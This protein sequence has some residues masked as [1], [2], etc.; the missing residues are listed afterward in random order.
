MDLTTNKIVEIPNC[1]PIKENG[2]QIGYYTTPLLYSSKVYFHG[3][4]NTWMIYD[5][6]TQ[7]GMALP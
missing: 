3:Y 1:K 6:S 5:L 4:C 7:L 2:P